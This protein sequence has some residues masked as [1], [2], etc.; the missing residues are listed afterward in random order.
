MKNCQHCGTELANK[1][2]KN[3][4]T[5]SAILND[6]YRSGA[7]GQVMQAIAEAKEV[8]LEADDVHAVMRAAMSAGIEE[9]NRIADEIRARAKARA[10]E[11]SAEIREYQ[12]TGR[13]NGAEHPDN[14]ENEEPEI[15]DEQRGTGPVGYDFNN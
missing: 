13:W 1:R 2:A 4:P 12:R 3:C 7:Y 6:A 11:K 8:G 9:H 5:C 14:I 10:E 15:P